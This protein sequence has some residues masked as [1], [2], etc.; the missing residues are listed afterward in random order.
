MQDMACS[1]MMLFVGLLP[2]QTQVPNGSFLFFFFLEGGG[3]GY[4]PSRLFHSFWAESIVRVGRKQEIPEKNHLT[5]RKQNFACLM[6]DPSMF[7]LG[8]YGPVN[9]E[10]MLCRSVNSGTIRG[11]A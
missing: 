2:V 7:V 8:F 5:T 3:G 4:G 11:Q 10:V 9:N 6:C 1:E